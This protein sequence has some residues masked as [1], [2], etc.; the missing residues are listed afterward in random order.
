MSRLHN[1]DNLIRDKDRDFLGDDGHYWFAFL[2]P[3][4]S[5]ADEHHRHVYQVRDDGEL[6]DCTCPYATNGGACTLILCARDV[7]RRARAMDDPP[8]ADPGGAVGEPP[9]LAGLS[10][11][12][13]AARDARTLDAAV[14]AGGDR[15]LVSRSTGR[16]VLTCASCAGTYRFDGEDQARRF[17]E[18]AL[19]CDQCGGVAGPTPPAPG[20]ARKALRDHLD[21]LYGGS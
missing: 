12:E 16:V 8:P 4:E 11:C 17:V 15:W 1:P 19:P 18:L 14:A 13:D 21:V 7:A 6:A 9:E 10:A 2:C 20:A 5:R 3:S